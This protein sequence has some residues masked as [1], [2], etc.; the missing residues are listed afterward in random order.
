MKSIKT[1]RNTMSSTL[2]NPKSLTA[3][4]DKSSSIDDKYLKKLEEKVKKQEEE[5]KFLKKDNMDKD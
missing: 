3:V 1:T 2:T 5:I 4:T